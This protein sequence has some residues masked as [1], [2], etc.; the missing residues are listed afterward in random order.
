MFSPL[1]Q[2]QAVLSRNF[3][4]SSLDGRNK[5]QWFPLQTTSSKVKFSRLESS[6]SSHSLFLHLLTSLDFFRFNFCLTVCDTVIP[7]IHPYS[8]YIYSIDVSPL[9]L[10]SL[11]W[12]T[13]PI[14]PASN[15]SPGHRDIE[16]REDRRGTGHFGGHQE[17][18]SR[19]VG[20]SAG[21]RCQ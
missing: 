20:R 8:P 7:H 17:T 15:P 18:P 4:D 10:N 6:A 16:A 13:I 9:L 12:F 11:V 5:N 3:Q 14:Q 1:R 19:R 21:R 2:R